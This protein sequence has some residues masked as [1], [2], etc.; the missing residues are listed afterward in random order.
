MD[1]DGEVY[2]GARFTRLSRSDS[3][4]S[5]STTAVFTSASGSS[6]ANAIELSDE[7]TEKWHVLQKA[8]DKN[9]ALLDPTKGLLIGTVKAPHYHIVWARLTVSHNVVNYPEDVDRY[10][11][12][13]E[14]WIGNRRQVVMQNVERA[15]FWQGMQVQ[16]IEWL[17]K[18]YLLKAHGIK[19][20]QG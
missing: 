10:G 6:A 5:R 20:E 12:P 16:Q 11:E 7:D 2:V 13:V 17:A 18:E 1:K 15:A 3:P 19:S 9:E 4:F 14:Q 8:L